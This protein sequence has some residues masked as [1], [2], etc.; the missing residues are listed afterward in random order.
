MDVLQ[1]FLI[2]NR[3]NVRLR[4][5]FSELT[6]ELRVLWM[7]MMKEKSSRRRWESRSLAPIENLG[8]V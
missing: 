2:Q 5:F 7:V 4:V 3:D 8:R 6:L 1:E